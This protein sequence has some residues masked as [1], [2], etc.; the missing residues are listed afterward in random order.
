MSDPNPR[1]M[2]TLYRSSDNAFMADQVAQ[3]KTMPLDDRLELLFFMLLNTNSAVQYIAD[4]MQP[5]SA[6]IVGMP[7]PPKKVN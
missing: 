1:D 6:P 2:L 5:G 7:D 3:F 4:Q